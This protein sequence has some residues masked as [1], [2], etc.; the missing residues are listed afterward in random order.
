MT[1]VLRKAL[2]LGIVVAAVIGIF[3]SG[4][5][6]FI[7]NQ[8]AL[9]PLE[10][11]A[12]DWFLRLRPPLPASGSPILLI[13]IT[14]RDLQTRGE[15]VISDS[16]LAAALKKVA[17][18]GPAAIGLDLYRDMPVPPGHRELQEVFGNNPLIIAPMKI[19]EGGAI[20]IS[21]P[22]PFDAASVQVGFT[23]LLLDEDS[24]VR[25]ALLFLD[26]GKRHFYSFALRL[27]LLYLGRVGIGLHPDGARPDYVRLGRSRIPYLEA[28]E[29]G[30]AALDNR[31]YQFLLDY[32]EARQTFPSFDL[33]ALFANRIDADAVRGKIVLLGATATSGSHVFTVPVATGE[34][35]GRT[36]SGLVVHA[37]VVSQLLRYAL[38]GTPPIKTLTV[39][40]AATWLTVWGLLGGVAGLNL[41]SA[42]RFSLVLFGGLAGLTLLAYGAFLYG[43]WV[44]LVPPAFSW[45]GSTT[46]VTMYVLTR[47]RKEALAARTARLISGARA[48]AT[49]L[50]ADLISSGTGNY[51]MRVGVYEKTNEAETTLHPYEYHNVIWK[52]VDDACSEIVAL[53][54]AANTHARL[55]SEILSGL[56]KTG[57][58]LFHVLLPQNAR[59]KLYRAESRHL[60]INIDDKLVQVPWELLFDGREF[61]G[62]RFAIGRVVTTPRR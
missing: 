13:T 21:P 55:P 2:R 12:Y 61:I 11:A 43:W 28:N 26:D 62:R 16:T 33:D 37:N 27:A 41:R 44:P 24:V 18:F 3:L 52:Q 5:I 56:K 10:L 53:L 54:N 32:R 49:V 40:S 51:R 39:T 45:S 8:G 17:G 20:E 36:L 29:G 42:W 50:F 19:G 1:R 47:E 6:I 48:P 30:Y 38:E 35:P 22:P 34:T 23:D 25:R 4:G 31:G 15:S 57:Q 14:E 9:E 58:M 7:R 46:L 59:E 60:I